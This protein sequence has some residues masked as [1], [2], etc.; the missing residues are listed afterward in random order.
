MALD[1]LKRVIY[2]ENTLIQVVCQFRFPRILSI[3]E[4]DPVDFQEQIRTEY[5]INNTQ[6]MQQQALEL[7]VDI[8]NPILTPKIMQTET[9]KNYSFISEDGFWN[10]NLTNTFL[11][12][13]TTKYES[14]EDFSEKLIKPLNALNEIYKP[15]FFERIG[16]RYVNAIKRSKFAL[17]NEPWNELI[18]PFALGFLSNNNATV[19]GYN[20][21]SELAMENNV[22][23]R[24]NSFLGIE[25][26]MDGANIQSSETALIIDN[27]IYFNEKKKHD[28]VNNALESL[29]SVSTELIQMVLKDKL[30]KAMKPKDIKNGN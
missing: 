15:A 1:D 8:A 24:V 26:N 6:I 9:V 18:E 23:A 2:E 21:S 4:K 27:D 11:S 28:E 5:P 12:L 10:V 3:N 17:Q 30:R 16:L 7:N 22:F 13:S 29:H 14:W 19:I 20:S 25:T